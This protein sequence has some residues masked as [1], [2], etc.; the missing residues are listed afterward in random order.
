MG[1]L[2]PLDPDPSPSELPLKFGRFLLLDVLGEGGMGAVFRAEMEG[3]QGF[4]KP[5][6]LKVMHPS[7]AM[8]ARRMGIDL[9]NEAKLG[10]LLHHPGIVEVYDFGITF[11]QPWMAME[12][13]DGTELSDLLSGAGVLPVTAVLDLGKQVCEALEHAHQLRIG[14][15]LVEV[16]HRDLK[17]SNLLV[18]RDGRVRIA[19]FGVAKA[20]V[21]NSL[22]TRTGI[23]KGTPSYMSPEQASATPVDGA[24]DLFSLG[25]ILYQALTGK[26][27]FYAGNAAATVVEVLKVDEI[28]HKR[29]VIAELDEILPGLGR[30]LGMALRRRPSERWLSA[31]LMGDALEDL[32]IR[33]GLGT[34]LAEWIET[35]PDQGTYYRGLRD[36]RRRAKGSGPP[37]FVV[38][39]H[40]VGIQRLDGPP[41]SIP[42]DIE[43]DSWPVAP[44]SAT[45]ISAIRTSSRPFPA[46]I[47]LAIAIGVLAAF[48]LSRAPFPEAPEL[49][50]EAPA[51]PTVTVTP[52]PELPWTFVIEGAPIAGGEVWVKQA[53]GAWVGS[54]LVS[55][56]AGLWRASVDAA[57][58]TVH[59]FVLLDEDQ[60]TLH[61][62]Q[63]ATGSR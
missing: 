51:A 18:G 13:V 22:A 52:D 16:V 38:S 12:L 58:G 11:G 35:L 5:C 9:K 48:G 55:V 37:P 25:V 28:L 62:V 10:A 19:D 43:L 36:A 1:A 56:G 23:T 34:N 60:V 4:R 24:S 17:P 47:P 54:P 32:E 61:E 21:L 31:K 6:A 15:R 63:G 53:P 27:L 30:V 50:V 39:E 7:V 8:A 42:D 46:R 33:A 29:G 45:G 59:R 14:G 40:L 2:Q 20:V 44:P 49:L 41:P 3:P 26:R 57:P